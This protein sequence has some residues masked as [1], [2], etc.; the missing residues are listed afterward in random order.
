MSTGVRPDTP[1]N[2]PAGPS[3]PVR[4]DR[5]D[6]SW[7]RPGRSLLWRAAWLWAGLPL[8]R[9][10]L[11]PFSGFRVALLR[12]FGAKVGSGVVIH[13]EAVVKYP[14]HLVV[15]DHCWLGERC[16]IDNLT[17]VTLESQVCISQGAYLC[18]GNHDWT[19]PAFGLRVLPITL[20]EGSWAGARCT[21]LPGTV[22]E[23]GAVAGA[24]SVISGIVPAFEIWSGNPA[25][26]VRMRRV[27][28][29][30]SGEPKLPPGRSQNDTIPSSTLW[31]PD[32]VEVEAPAR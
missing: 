17:T 4:L 19:D 5:Y 16:W 23:R 27:L 31:P 1:L 8:F 9:C 6:N 32:V 15:G 29:P 7:F 21:L 2:A 10:S 13:S 3:G 30:T 20:H 22:L 11:L 12:L 24:G 18:T 14:W 28:S 26:F 25:A